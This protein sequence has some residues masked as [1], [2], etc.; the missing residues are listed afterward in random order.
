MTHL[1]Q[2]CAD[3]RE[4]AA[5]GR[6]LAA[7]GGRLEALLVAAA[8]QGLDQEPLTSSTILTGSA[9]TIIITASR[10]Q[11]SLALCQQCLLQL[12]R[13]HRCLGNRSFHVGL[14]R[15]GSDGSYVIADTCTAYSD[16][17]AC[18]QVLPYLH[19]RQGYVHCCLPCA[20]RSNHVPVQE[21]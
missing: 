14:C 4:V 7:V 17:S 20:C 11:P 16:K 5:L 19:T 1:I 3:C 13:L 18:G 12:Q 9:L 10:L 21:I 8:S 6:S 15:S 2:R